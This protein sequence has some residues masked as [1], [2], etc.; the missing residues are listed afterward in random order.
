[1]ESEDAMKTIHKNMKCEKCEKCGATDAVSY[2]YIMEFGAGGDSEAAKYYYECC[3][4]GMPEGTKDL[5]IIAKVE[6]SNGLVERS[7]QAMTGW[8]T[9]EPVDKYGNVACIKCGRIQAKSF[10][11]C[12]QCCEHEELTF[13]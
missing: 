11:V 2:W 3:D 4:C 9:K 13:M 7:W 5:H 1:M 6:I 12:I 8:H 10:K